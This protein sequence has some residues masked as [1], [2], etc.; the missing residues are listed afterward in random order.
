MRTLIAIPCMDMVHTDFMRAVLALQHR[1]ETQFTFSQA[2]LVYDGRNRLA[3]AAIAGGFDRVLWLDSDMVFDPDLEIR[4]HDDLDQGMEMVSALYF[5]R[6]PPLRPV[7]YSEIAKD[8]IDGADHPRAESF[9]DYPRDTLFPVAGCGFGAVMMTTDL[10]QRVR[11][12]YGLPFSPLIGFGED[13][14]FCLRVR[15][16]GR[17]IWCDSRIRCGHV[18]TAVYDEALYRQTPV[19]RV[20]F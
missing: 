17:V 7:V 16:L 3:D 1:D 9:L 10:L 15:E 18:G 4:L 19:R 8:V 20:N 5:T 6:K 12:R 2:S 13:F 14:S 11:S